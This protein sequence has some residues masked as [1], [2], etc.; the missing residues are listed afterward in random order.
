MISY[1]SQHQL[2]S[3]VSYERSSCSLSRFEE[4]RRGVRAAFALLTEG[5]RIGLISWKHSECAIASRWPGF[6]Y[7]VRCC[8]VAVACYIAPIAIYSSYSSYIA[9]HSCYI[10]F[11]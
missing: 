3:W 11:V 1:D 8:Q 6:Q 4:L 5:G 10:A 9:I 7:G 2:I